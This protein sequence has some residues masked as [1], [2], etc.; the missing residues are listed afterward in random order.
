MKNNRM[1]PTIVVLSYLVGV[2]L[3]LFLVVV[4]T[5]ADLE[6]TFYGFFH[7][8]NTRFD[9]LT[10]PILMTPNETA[11]FSVTV[12][13]TADRAL[14]P[15]IKVD[16]SARGA[17]F[18]SIERLSLEPGESEQVFWDIGPENIDI[19]R[20]IFAQVYVYSFYPIPDSENTCG[21]FIVNLPGNGTVIA[22]AMAGL[23]LLGMGFGLS[24]LK[25][26]PG[27]THRGAGNIWNSMMF[28]SLVIVIGL[29]ASFMGW[30]VQGG[31]LLIVAVLL[32]VIMLG[33]LLLHFR[34][35]Y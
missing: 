33:Q 28:L 4:S 29:V 13:N 3:G 32:V 20:F 5:W 27:L 14:S 10:C 17:L 16:T 6:S 22:W 23:S 7:R 24:G 19:D 18:S 35:D 15:T 30:W 12:T 34:S 21:I 2:V 9:G 25:K 26:F 31:F 1:F 8:T 11:S